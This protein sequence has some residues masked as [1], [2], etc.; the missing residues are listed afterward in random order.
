[1][2][3]HRPPWLC[4][5]WTPLAVACNDD[6]GA[7]DSA[8][9]SGTSSSSSTGP[10]LPTTTDSIAET[11]PNTGSTSGISGSGDP[12]S[13]ATGASEP[14]TSTGE[15]E[16]AGD[17]A[18]PPTPCGNAELDRGEDCDLG[19]GV[20]SQTGACTLLC[21]DA[22]CG[23]GLVWTGH[24][25]CDNGP[26]NNDAIYDGCTTQCKRGP[27]CDDMVQDP[28]ECD[29]GDA[30]GT[31]AFPPN[32]VPCDIGCRFKARLVFIS[33]AVYKG[34]DLGGV[35]GADLKCQNLA[36]QAKLDNAIG[37][38]AW[39]SDAQH[40]PN[41]DFKHGP[42]TNGLPY[43][44]R[45]G[46]LVA[47]DWTDLI[48]NGPVV[49]IIRTEQKEV[50]PNMPVTLLT[51]VGVWTG[52]TAIGNFIGGDNDCNSWT[53]SSSKAKGH[54]GLSGVDPQQEQALDQ[55]YTDRQWTNYLTFSCDVE[56]RIYC[57]EQ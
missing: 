47:K 24:E 26:K 5:L 17:S 13:T 57:F 52:T 41:K 8:G 4:L 27:H 45:D 21:K 54:R 14:T 28:E 23:D 3:H 37:F 16:T 25:E 35:D 10:P 29:N 56:R 18:H 40:S 38:K 22:I 1:M 49:G 51:N 9:Y 39:L 30:N 20:N 31:E 15:T 43:V 42:E 46:W 12:T 7:S 50:Q 19:H 36:K 33:S 34:G 2:L 53:N 32:S 48:L 6:T 44:R 11:T 55:W